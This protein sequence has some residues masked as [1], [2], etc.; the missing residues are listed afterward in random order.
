MRAINSDDADGLAELESHF[1]AFAAAYVMVFW[2]LVHAVWQFPATAFLYEPSKCQ[3]RR[4]WVLYI[5]WILPSIALIATGEYSARHLIPF[6]INSVPALYSS[7][8]QK[9]RLYQR[10]C[11]C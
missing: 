5:G 8:W 6:R 10:T 7:G 9:R 1:G 2:G 11:V 3:P 4:L